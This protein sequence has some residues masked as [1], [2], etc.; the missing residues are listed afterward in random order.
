MESAFKAISFLGIIILLIT[1]AGGFLLRDEKALNE[2]N[3]NLEAQLTEDAL[4]IEENERIAEE[5]K[6]ELDIAQQKIIELED[7]IN[8]LQKSLDEGNA[9]ISELQSANEMKTQE[10][11]KLQEDVTQLTASLIE[12]GRKYD[13]VSMEKQL[14][15]ERYAVVENNMKEAQDKAA[16]LDEKLNNQRPDNWLA[17][18]LLIIAA[19]V[20]LPVMNSVWVRFQGKKEEVVYAQTVAVLPAFRNNANQ[21]QMLVTREEARKLAR[22]RRNSR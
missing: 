13:Q 12:A 10:A 15:E 16:E 14:L 8:A 18:A 22:N 6:K 19:A 20:G 7:Q 2:E 21:V 1:G 17:S 9:R 3:A 5:A 4:T 11:Q